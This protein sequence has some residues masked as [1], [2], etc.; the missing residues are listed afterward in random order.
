M[1]NLCIEVLALRGWLSIR[2]ELNT[3]PQNVVPNLWRESAIIRVEVR[4]WSE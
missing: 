3:S 2:A 4:D 1:A